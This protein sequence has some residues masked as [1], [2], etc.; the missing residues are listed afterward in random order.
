MFLGAFAIVNIPN[1]DLTLSW[2]LLWLVL[3]A[4][5]CHSRKISIN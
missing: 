2:T 1:I 3:L 4:Q 5:N